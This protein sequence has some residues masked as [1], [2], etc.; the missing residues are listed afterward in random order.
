M[1]NKNEEGI[2]NAV[3]PADG[4]QKETG[5]T[6]EMKEVKCEDKKIRIGI[7]YPYKPTADDG[8]SLR[9]SIRS[10]EKHLMLDTPYDFEPDVVVIGPEK[11][12][13][14]KDE[15][16]ILCDNQCRNA[17]EAKIHC[18]GAYFVRGNCA[19]KFVLMSDDMFIINDI[20]LADIE[21]LKANGFLPESDET[22]MMLRKNHNPIYDYETHLPCMMSTNVAKQIFDELD[23]NIDLSK[24]RL[25]SL[26][27]NTIFNK[28][29]PIIL[30]WKEDSWVL[31][32]A[33]V[34]PNRMLVDD[35][36]KHTKF[37]FF[38]KGAYG[39]PNK[40]LIGSLFDAAS[41]CETSE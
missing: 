3:I 28:V 21:V 37:M 41:E 17:H 1:E 9:H 12:S 31:P 19:D 29:V 32:I 20:I 22:A 40:A 25:R 15:N 16:F 10:I 4:P 14:L 7:I 39:E 36:L 38:H 24:L 30:N 26:Y 23:G 34:S 18:I 13:W 33:N 5:D 2:E 35:N 8:Y 6:P 11:P 27:F